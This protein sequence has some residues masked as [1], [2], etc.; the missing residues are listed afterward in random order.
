M[1][2]QRDGSETSPNVAPRPDTAG[3]TLLKIETDSGE[4]GTLTLRLQGDLDVYSA[5]EL[6]NRFRKVEPRCTDVVVDLSGLK[7]LD[8]AGVRELVDAARRA[9]ERGCRL[10]L[11]EGPPSVQRV[12]SLARLDA[13]LYFLAAPA[14]SR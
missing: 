10:T 6:L 7:F 12:F 3:W 5:G 2:G 14:V 1:D 11:I 4:D 8:C 13:D 9:E